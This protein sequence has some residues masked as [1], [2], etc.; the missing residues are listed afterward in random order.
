MRK[1][2]MCVL[3]MTC[4]WLLGGQTVSAQKYDDKEHAEL[5]KALVG[6]KV[7][8][9]EGLSASER[10][11]TPISG[12]FELEEGKLQLSVYTMKDDKF[13]EVIVDH[14]TGKVTEVE[15]I[16]S[17][18]DLTAAKA[19]QAAMA[20]AKKSLRTVVDAAVKAN[21]GFRAVS[22]VPALK[23]EH[24]VAELTLLKENAFKEVM[25]PLD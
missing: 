25:E 3:V 24:P 19:Q 22:I 17:G 14:T 8:L 9:E 20:K 5:A 11:G 21:T 15:A 6:V 1:S 2:I 23:G 16:T 4:V 12:K 13:S 7:S 18:K 10:E